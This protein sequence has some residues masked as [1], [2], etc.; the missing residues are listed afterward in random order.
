MPKIEISD[1]A[2]EYLQAFAV[3][4]QDTTVTAMD[5][6]VA[7][8]KD[9]VTKPEAA[10]MT[11]G[12]DTLPNVAFTTII[13]AKIEDK[14]PPQLYWNNML[15]VLVRRALE[16]G[17]E[18][19]ELRDAIAAN[20]VEGESHENGYRYSVEGDFSYQGMDAQRACKSIGRISKL[21]NISV[22]IRLR[23]QDNEKAAHPGAEA[24]LV[25]P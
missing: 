21:A 12:T 20:S 24:D 22:R 5:R 6:L 1:S 25:F 13:S 11:F 15:D 14:T 18:V 23:W 7:Q 4:L 2:Y 17:Y 3:P 8:H 10:G 9:G 16:K 19:S